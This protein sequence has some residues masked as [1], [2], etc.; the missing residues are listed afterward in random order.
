[1]ETKAPP[2]RGPTS[3]L[4]AGP[5]HRPRSKQRFCAR[6]TV[7]FLMH[8]RLDEACGRFIESGSKEARELE[9]VQAVAD[10]TKIA[11]ATR[12]VDMSELRS[13]TIDRARLIDINR[14]QWAAIKRAKAFLQLAL[15]SDAAMFKVHC[16]AALMALRGIG[17]S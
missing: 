10:A 7:S 1:M 12:V 4:P 14:A 11:D 3:Y 2:P 16:Q 13:D 17:E 8:D 5:E 15:D 9:A 6:C